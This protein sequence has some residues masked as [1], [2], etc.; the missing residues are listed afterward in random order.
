MLVACH[1][2]VRHFAATVERLAG[3]VLEH[4]SD[5]AAREAAAGVLRYFDVAAPLHHEDEEADLFPALVEALDVTQ[6]ADT[7]A[8][9]R[10][11]T[12]EHVELAALYRA[13]RVTLERIAAGEPARFAA[14]AAESFAR[15]YPAHAAAEEESVFPIAQA[16]LAKDVLADI[17]RRMASRRGLRE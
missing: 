7:L 12:A 4:G 5:E 14:G 15:R 17:G 16:R 13:V 8:T 2:R 1:D 3:H 11:L 10:R 6:D 9:L